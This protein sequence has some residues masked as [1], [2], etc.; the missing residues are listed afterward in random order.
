M[1]LKVGDKV[2]YTFPDPK[3]LKETE[4]IGIVEVLAESYIYLKNELNIRLKV[5][6]KNFHLINIYATHFN[7]SF[8]NSEIFF[9]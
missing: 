2:R 5:S 7:H 8:T 1:E 4:F 9:G 3:N 6:Y